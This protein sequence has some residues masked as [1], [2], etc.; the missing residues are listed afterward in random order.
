MYKRQPQERSRLLFA[1]RP[2]SFGDLDKLCVLSRAIQ[3]NDESRGPARTS[4][5]EFRREERRAVQFQPRPEGFAGDRGVV[6]FRCSRQGHVARN[7]PEGGL[8][9]TIPP[10][11]RSSKN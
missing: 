2:R 7:C 3:V 8:R 6:C 1:E 5:S 9:P 10:R 4:Q 11:V